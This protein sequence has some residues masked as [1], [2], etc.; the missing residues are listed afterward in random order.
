MSR[1]QLTGGDVT[2]QVKREG[3][4]PA[5]EYV[6]AVEFGLEDGAGFDRDSDGDQSYSGIFKAFRGGYTVV[7]KVTFRE[8]ECTRWNLTIEDVT[9]ASA[10][11][12]PESDELTY[13]LEY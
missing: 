2:V 5:D 7:L 13:L 10:K 4:A 8:Y 12:G 11:L 6:Q 1:F 9:V 3:E